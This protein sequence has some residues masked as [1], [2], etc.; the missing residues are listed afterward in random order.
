MRFLLSILLLSFSVTA[1]CQFPSNPSTQNSSTNLINQGAG[2]FNKG[3]VIGYYIDTLTANAATYVKS[4]PFIRI[5]TAGNIEWQRTADAQR[6]VQTSL[7]GV[8]CISNPPIVTWFELLIFNGTSGTYCINGT[9]YFYAGGSVTLTAADGSLPRQDAI[10]VDTFGNMVAIAGTPAA[11]PAV[12]SIDPASQYFLTSVL[13]GAGATTPTG[14]SSV[15]IYDQNSGAPEW[16]GSA[17]GLI[18]AFSNTNNPYHLNIAADVGTFSQGDVVTFTGTPYLRTAYNSLRMFIRLKS[19]IANN[20]NISVQLMAGGS[21]VTS[22]LTL[23]SV[24]GFSKTT[25]GAY[26]NISVALDNFV[27]IN[28][29]AFT[30]YQ[31]SH[32]DGLRFIMTGANALG[33]YLDYITFNTGTSTGSSNGI[34]DIYRIPGTDSVMGVKNGVPLLMF[35]DSIG[36]GG[37]GADTWQQVIDA[38]VAADGGVY[39]TFADKEYFVDYAKGGNSGY[40]WYS[41]DSLYSF[42]TKTTLDRNTAFS[43]KSN[44]IKMHAPAEIH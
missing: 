40:V 6:W 38:S 9:Q 5:T 44:E 10:V 24:Q 1:V 20:A 30:D 8:N 27:Y 23:G 13:V 35:R 26:Q 12:P 39:G 18:V 14:P 4:V 36:S 34:T 29:P 37:G 28:N 17:S 7:G 33:Y 15:I 21:A 43:Q 42:L 11:D 3:A 25:T 32:F 2:T 31:N 19:N 22:P 41:G 16:A